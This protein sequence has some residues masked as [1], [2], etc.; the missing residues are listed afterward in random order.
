MRLP[1]TCLLVFLVVRSSPLSAASAPEDPVLQ[2]L[3]EEALIANP[4][5]AAARHAVF[6]AKARPDQAGSRPGPKAG[7]FYQNDGWSPSLGREPM[8]L[9]GVMGEQE[10]PYPGKLD[11]RRSMAESDAAA[12]SAELE[13][14]RLGLIGSVRRAYY[15]LLLA[16]DLAEL[17]QEHREIW[18]EIQETARARYA[19]AVGSQQELLRAQVEATRLNAIHIQH[20]AEARARLAE[21]NALRGRPADTPVETAARL[22]LSREPRSSAEW[23]QWFEA[24]SPELLAAMAAVERDERGLSLAHLESKPDF[25]VQGGVM[26]RGS[27]PPMWQASGTVMLQSRSRARAAQSE[28]EARLAGSRARV[29]AVQLRIRAVVEQ[30]LALIQAAEE[31]ETTYREGLLPQGQVAVDSAA[32]R[33]AAGQGPQAGVL[34]AMSGILEDRIDYLRL[35]ATHEVERSR[36]D[37]ASLETP[38]GIDTLLSHGRS[39]M[40]REAMPSPAAGGATSAQ[41][42]P[43]NSMTPR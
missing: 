5:L 35:L 25:S 1:S 12:S 24:R 40:P 32:A 16:R 9:L 38:T 8:T 4:E 14:S 23:V 18:R 6:A 21:L 10:L 30:R 17:A 34:D 2:A 13:R 28:A 33:Y 7:V 27:L 22:S 31:I 11:L 19:S 3:I 26:Y 36:L 15:G 37:E 43:S 41:A 20:H 29:Q 42:T 39:G